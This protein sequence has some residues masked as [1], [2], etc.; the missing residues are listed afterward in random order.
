MTQIPP[1]YCSAVDAVALAGGVPVSGVVFLLAVVL[2]V[3]GVAIAVY[4]WQK[5]KRKDDLNIS[6]TISYY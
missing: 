2:V 6:K 5:R 1:N 4:R 3:I